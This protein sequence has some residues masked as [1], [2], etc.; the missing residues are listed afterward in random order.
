M[1]IEAQARAIRNRVDRNLKFGIARG[2]TQVAK[3][4]SEKMTQQLPE[5][6]D[7][8]TPFTQR[9][10]GFAPASRTK[11]EARVFVRDVQAQY[12]AKQETGGTRVPKPGSPINVPV[13][14]NINRYG[15]IARGGI[16]R[17]RVRPDTFVSN[18][19]GR[20]KHLPPGLYQRA[21]RTK[22]RDG[23]WGTGGAL[24]QGGKGKKLGGKAARGATSLK[25]LV[26]FERQAQYEPRFRFHERVEKIVQ[27]NA[28]RIVSASIADAM[29]TMK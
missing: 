4:A 22:R 13:G 26:A 10:M 23:T 20:T 29:R 2:L 7:R 8:P 1:D 27:A 3:F 12:L 6:F 17:K 19:K 25:L 14:I 9:A 28:K 18:Q 5:I 15:N 24:R 11:M 16:T 21:K